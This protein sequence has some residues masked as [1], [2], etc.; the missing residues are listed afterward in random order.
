MKHKLI[1]IAILFS[2]MLSACAP[3]GGTLEV[4]LVPETQNVTVETPATPT[5]IPPTQ[6]PE[7]ISSTGMVMG[8]ICFPSEFIPSMTVYF[9]DITTGEFTEMHVAENQDNYTLEL[10]SGEYVAFAPLQEVETPFGGMYS[11]AVLCGLSVE[12]T[13]HSLVEFTVLAEETTEGIDICD[14]YAPELVP[15]PPGGF[16]QSGPFQDIAGLVYSDL[17]AEETWRIDANGF[18]Q[19]VY[20]ERD[21]S[22]SPD[23]SKVLLDRN[24]DIWLVDLIS[25]EETNLTADTNR[26]EGGGRWWPANPE[27]LVFSSVNDEWGMSSGQASI[28]MQDGSGYQVLDENSSFWS[29][30]PSPDGNA[31]LYIT[32]DAAWF[33]HLDAGK[34]PINF[35][36]FG[37]IPPEDFKLGIPSWSPDGTKLAWWVGGS[38]SD[39]EWMIALLVFDLPSRSFQFLHQYQPM[40][41]GSG[42]WG[43]PAEWSPDG[44]WLAFTTQ[45]QGRVPNIVIMRVDGSQSTNIGSGA[46]PLWSPD[47]SQLIF[48]HPDPGGGSFLEDDLMIVNREDWLAMPLDLPPGSRHIQWDSP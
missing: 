13:D 17:P 12:C 5:T 16:T 33:Y 34:E 47:S 4:D 36:E 15:H 20:P 21:A 38:F 11:E 25:D 26:L 31:I 42:V 37:L 29:P 44:E 41:G 28:M 14:W 32:G 43:S 18:P 3:L 48:L 2:A 30:A 9:Q 7:P 35:G 46:M 23:G 27:V 24:D 8:K 45:G 19:L 6:E 1:S 40:G 10:E 22:L 39:G